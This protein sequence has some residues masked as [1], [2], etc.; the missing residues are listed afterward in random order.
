MGGGWGREGVLTFLAKAV[1]KH[2]AQ[3][4]AFNETLAHIDLTFIAMLKAVKNIQRME[5][6][7]EKR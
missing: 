4:T 7:R 3:R 2:H 1:L 5:T 6:R